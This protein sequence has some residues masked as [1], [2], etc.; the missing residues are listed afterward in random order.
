MPASAVRRRTMY[1]TSGARHRP[2]PE[3]PGLA[4]DSAE[5]WSLAIGI[6]L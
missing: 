5:Q 6:R 3:F 4:D 1:Q 2:P